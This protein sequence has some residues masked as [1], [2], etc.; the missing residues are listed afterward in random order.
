MTFYKEFLLKGT[1]ETL[2]VF[3]NDMSITVEISTIK[4]LGQGTYMLP[5]ELKYQACDS[6]RCLFPRTLNFEIMVDVGS[7]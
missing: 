7:K 2:L 1:E 3:D 6:V 4:S 5:G